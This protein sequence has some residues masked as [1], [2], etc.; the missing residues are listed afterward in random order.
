MASFLCQVRPDL[1]AMKF[2]SAAIERL[3]AHHEFTTVLDIGSGAGEQAKALRSHGKTVTELDYGKSKYFVLNPDE[4][5]A[6]I[7]DFMEADIAEQFDCVI[8]SHVLEHQLNV[9][10]FLKKVH[11]VVKEGGV[12]AISVPP[13]KPQIVGG[14]VTLW[15]AGLLLYNLVVAGF[16]CSNPWIRRYGNNISLVIQKKTIEPQGLEYDSGD[17]DRIQAYLPPGCKE[18]FDGDF[19]EYGD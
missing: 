12:V 9:G 1:R 15:N 5:G 8:A 14:H 6:I 13:L 11:G 4:G 10:A 17:I 3:L 18:G 19:L 7:G 2:S 16:D